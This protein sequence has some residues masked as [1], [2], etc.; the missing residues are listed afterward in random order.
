M[1]PGL[2]PGL[3]TRACKS[4]KSAFADSAEASHDIPGIMRPMVAG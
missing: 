3:E 2:H 1:H 4:R